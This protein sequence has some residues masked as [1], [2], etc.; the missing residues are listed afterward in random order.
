MA[1]TVL[2]TLHMLSTQQPHKLDAIITHNPQVKGR[3]IERLSSL[4]QVAQHHVTCG[5]AGVL[6]G[7]L[8]QAGA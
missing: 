1:G 7:T 8:T 6:D 4:P 3:D 5:A 2:S